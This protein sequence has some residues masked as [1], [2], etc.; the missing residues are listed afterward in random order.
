MIQQTTRS[1]SVF[2]ARRTAAAAAKLVDFVLSSQSG[3]TVERLRK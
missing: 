1:D 2:E 3:T